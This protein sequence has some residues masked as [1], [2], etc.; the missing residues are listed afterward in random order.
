MEADLKLDYDIKNYNPYGR[1]G[2]GAPIVK[3]ESVMSYRQP[4]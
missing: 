1:G 3:E 4:P 2:G